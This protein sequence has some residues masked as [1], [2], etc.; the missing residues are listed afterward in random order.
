MNEENKS[1]NNNFQ[2]VHEAFTTKEAIDEAKR[3]LHCKVPQCRKGCPIEN[4]IPAFTSALAMGNIGQAMS[5]INERSNLPAI[6]GRLQYLRRRRRRIPL[7][8]PKGNGSGGDAPAGA[9]NRN[10]S[11]KFRVLTEQFF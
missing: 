10:Q 4:D 3:C 7:G 6:C 2:V 5:I 8:A 11:G 9:E 1:T